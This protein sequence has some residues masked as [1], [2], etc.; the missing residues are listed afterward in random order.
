MSQA[1]YAPLQIQRDHPASPWLRSLKTNPK[2]AKQFCDKVAKNMLGDFS[3]W[4]PTRIIGKWAAEVWL[5]AGKHTIPE[6]H[7]VTCVEGQVMQM[8]KTFQATGEVIFSFGPNLT[9]ELMQ[10]DLEDARIRDLSPPAECFYVVYEGTPIIMPDGREMEGFLFLQASADSDN[11]NNALFSN[12]GRVREII[13]L[14]K[15]CNWGSQNN[16]PYVITIPSDD[17]NELVMTAINNFI[18]REAATIARTKRQLLSNTSF[19]PLVVAGAYSVA[20]HFNN[21]TQAC[22]EALH[23]LIAGSLLYLTSY[24]DQGKIGW[25]RGAPEKLVKRVQADGANAAAS[26]TRL[27][28]AGWRDLI[29]FEVRSSSTDGGGI[30][31]NRATH[32]RRGHWRQQAYGK[33]MMQRRMRWIR[34]T[35][36][37]AKPE[38]IVPSRHYHV[39]RPEKGTIIQ[40]PAVLPR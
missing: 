11:K 26:R 36:I 34:P 9:E 20:E 2:A 10:T 30:H 29:Y 13:I 31:G 4:S 5:K 19:D 7:I 35:L 22:A 37:N 15:G 21:K 12:S 16:S 38:A 28:A 33:G 3:S 25:P 24:H 17:D 8:M 14:P 32:W 40:K 27:E 23:R 18:E 6:H 1:H 39:T